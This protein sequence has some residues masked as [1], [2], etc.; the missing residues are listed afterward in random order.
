MNHA[1]LIQQF[2]AE[3]RDLTDLPEYG[4]PFVTISREA[5]AGGHLLSYIILTEFLKEK[6]S[7]LFLGWHVFDK[8]LCEAVATNPLVQDS[9]E[10]LVT[11]KYRSEFRDFIESL[12]TGQ[13]SQYLTY[14]TTFRVVRMLALIGKV[15]IVGRAGSLVTADLNQGIHVRLVAP[16]AQRVVWMMKRFKLR[17]EEARQTVIKQDADRRKLVKMFFHRDIA[18]PLLYDVVWNTGRADLDMMARDIIELIKQRAAAKRKSRS[19]SAT[20]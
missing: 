2:L 10:T 7:D 14:K 20:R 1:K 15:I 17:K 9:M 5:G 18:D 12:F 4:F 16:E 11:E 19:G 8:A 6:D 13:S 3:K